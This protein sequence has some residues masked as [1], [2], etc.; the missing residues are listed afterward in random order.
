MWHTRTIQLRPRHRRGRGAVAV[1][2]CFVLIAASACGTKSHDSASQSTTVPSSTSSTTV[3]PTKTLNLPD[4]APAVIKGIVVG[5]FA[6][7]STPTIGSIDPVTG[8]YSRFVTFEMRPFGIKRSI[9][10]TEFSPDFTRVATNRAFGQVQHAGW[11]DIASDFIDVNADSPMPGPFDDA[12]LMSFEAIGFDGAG[13]FYYRKSKPEGGSGIVKVPAGQTSGGEPAEI[14]GASW[15]QY[16]RDG[17]GALHLGFDCVP[18]D[19]DPWISPTEYVTADGNQIN[20]RLVDAPGS[21]GSPGETPLLPATNTSD[22]SEAVPSPDG[23]QVAFRRNG[24]ELWIVSA[25]GGG[26][27]RQLNVTGID[28]SDGNNHVMGWK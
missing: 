14:T 6:D 25:L 9:A 28:L 8:R 11:I 12:D 5:S 17:N 24:S 1:A 23:Q 19:L 22:I 18:S 15:W 20:R 26:T 13:A 4:P 3:T 10:A 27:P 21:C 7:E 16:T 2:V